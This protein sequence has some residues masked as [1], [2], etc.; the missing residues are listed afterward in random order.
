MSHTPPV[1]AGNT[2]PYP[3]REAPHPHDSGTARSAAPVAPARSDRAPSSP[4][5]LT[6]GAL[7]G[8]G[9]AA[10]ASIAYVLGSNASAKPAKRNRK[11]KSRS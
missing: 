11:S 9:A 3:L 1:P 8:F 4:N 2:S 7:V 5:L 10:L 6:I